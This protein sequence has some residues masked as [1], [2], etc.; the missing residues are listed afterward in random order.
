MSDYVIQLGFD[1]NARPIA[2]DGELRPLEQAA[3]ER[4]DRGY[5]LATLQ[6]LEQK[7]DRIL[8]YL[9]DITEP[10]GEK[11]ARRPLS[12]EVRFKPYD[13]G[14]RTSSPCEVDRIDVSETTERYRFSHP[15]PLETPAFP[16]R[17]ATW[18]IT[19]D[20]RSEALCFPLVHGGKF[21]LIVWIV[22]GDGGCKKPFRV[23]PE[24]IVRGGG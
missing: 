15:E 1:W 2:A 23:D 21:A 13:E 5:R 6:E 7:R 3:V 24:M 12:A 10:A 18:S 14:E 22:V 4:R 9:T 17:Y 20:G 19:G 16:R 11:V 8:F